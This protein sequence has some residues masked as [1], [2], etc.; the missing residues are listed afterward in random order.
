VLVTFE[1][2]RALHVG[3]FVLMLAAAGQV[4]SQDAPASPSGPADT[5]TKNPWAY[6]L[7][8]DGYIVPNGESYA[9]PI[10]AADRNWLHLEARYNSENLRTGSLWLGYNF[11]AGQK[12]VLNLTPMLGGVFGRTTGIAPGCEL[13]LSYKKLQFSLVNE[14]VFDTSHSSGSF[15]Y[16]WPQL[17]YSLTDWLDVGVTAQHTKALQTAHST[18]RGL[19]VGVSHKKM[20]FTTYIFNPDLNDRIVVLEVG[21]SF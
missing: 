7:T 8:V 13:S 11:S 12:L 6:D 19:L 2:K 17:T 5:A 21:Y 15:Y 1:M 18:Q 10:F 4:R 14:Y 20:E 3:A 9:S 16:S